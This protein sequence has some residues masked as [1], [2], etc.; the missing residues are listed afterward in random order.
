M[1]YKSR[2]IG[3]M[4]RPNAPLTSQT[5]AAKA[6]RGRVRTKDRVMACFH[7]KDLDDQGKHWTEQGMCDL[8]LQ[9]RMDEHNSNPR[10]RREEL[11]TDDR[12][13]VAMNV[14][15][16]VEIDGNECEFIKHRLRN[17][18]D[19]YDVPVPQGNRN[20]KPRKRTHEEAL[21]GDTGLTLSF[22]SEAALGVFLKQHRYLSR[23]DENGQRVF[24]KRKSD[25]VLRY[26]PGPG[27]VRAEL[28]LQP[29]PVYT[30]EIVYIRETLEAMQ[31]RCGLVAPGPI[32]ARFAALS[33]ESETGS[34]EVRNADEP[35]ESVR[36][37]RDPRGQKFNRKTVVAKKR[38]QK[39]RDRRLDRR[40]TPQT[41]Y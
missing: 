28:S 37:R 5:A 17:E 33:A 16:I 15:V 24:A 2:P 12:L 36:K 30:G 39:R 3:H 8:E 1:A 38:E 9:M 25:I 21:V 34:T 41:T 6:S 22:D 31:E 13:L 4:V 11:R 19:P 29:G 26:T 14:I 7:H 18:T 35:I 27:V 23:P 32:L 10:S 40:K 20:G